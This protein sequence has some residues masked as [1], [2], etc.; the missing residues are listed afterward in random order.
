MGDKLLYV[1]RVFFHTINEVIF[2]LPIYG[3]LLSGSANVSLFLLL[4]GLNTAL[5][6]GVLTMLENRLDKEEFKNSV[7]AIAA[8]A[9]GMFSYILNDGG[10]EVLLLSFIFLL[11]PTII[12]FKSY[13]Q[14]QTS[15]EIKVIGGRF[16]IRAGIYLFFI[17]NA[18]TFLRVELSETINLSFRCFIVYVIL[19]LLLNIQNQIHELY[20]Y[21]SYD[22]NLRDDPLIGKYIGRNNLL[23]SNNLS[24]GQ[25]L[26]TSVIAPLTIIA[27]AYL[28]VFKGINSLYHASSNLFDTLNYYISYFIAN[29]LL[30]PIFA[31]MSYLNRNPVPLKTE[32]EEEA[33]STA[34]MLTREGEVIE[35]S[36]GSFLE[37]VVIIISIA[38]AAGLLYLLFKFVKKTIFPSKKSSDS[39]EEE[40]E[41]IPVFSEL[42]KKIKSK[43]DEKQRQR[44][45]FKKLHPIRRKYRELIIFLDKKYNC[46]KNSDT[47]NTILDKSSMRNKDVYKDLST[48]TNMY[49][50]LRYG[51]K[52]SINEEEFKRLCDG[53]KEQVK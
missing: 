2:I 7:F 47:P 34:E 22:E 46:I 29:V 1:S 26:L 31:L 36:Q 17:L 12:L 40:R 19:T 5:L 49:N 44:D 42:I 10:F 25:V 27:L 48:I 50:T 8:I 37:Y 15:L 20:V 51:E 11:I 33:E 23:T 39:Y 18:F 35:P 3:L 41:Q 16:F 28:F 52:S 13:N 30:R 21:N 14:P 45:Y 32:G 9:T 4:S 38:V 53:V 6:L 43:L 24:L